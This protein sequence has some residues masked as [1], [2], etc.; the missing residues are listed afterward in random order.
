MDPAHSAQD[1][2]RCYRC[3]TPAP[4]MHCD[5]CHIN[6][7]KACVVVHLSD[8]SKDH[9]VVSFNKRGSTI[10]YPICHKHSRKI[11]EV[12]CNS[13]NI[14]ICA[15]CVSLGYHDQ[16]EKVEI[17]G[18]V[19]GKKELIQKDLQELKKSIYPKYQQ[20]SSN[21]PDQKADVRNHSQKLKTVLDKQREILHTEIDT[22]IQGMKS[23]IDNMDAQHIAAIKRH[24]DTIN[25]TITEITR[26]IR[27][28]QD[29]LD[30]DDV[31]LV[32]EYKSRNNEF[33]NLPAQFQV[34]LPTFTPQQINRK[35]IYQQIGSLS[36]LAIHYPTRPLIDDLAIR[37]KEHGRL[38]KTPGAMSSLPAIPLFDDPVITME[39]HSDPI[40]TPRA[41]SSSPERV[42]VDVPWILKE[43]KTEYKALLRVSCLSENALWTC[44]D[45]DKIIKLYS[46]QGKLLKSVR[47]KSGNP[48]RDLVIT[49]SRNL[50]YAD[51][52]DSSINLV[53]DTQIQKLITLRGWRPLGVCSTSSGDLLVIMFSDDGKQ[54]KVVRYCGFSEKQSIQWDDEGEPLYTSSADNK[55]LCENRNLDICVT[56]YVAGAV[57]VVSAAGK[58]RFRYTGPPSPIWGSFKPD[59]ITTDIRANILIADGENHR[60]HIID[61]HGH[62]LRFIDK[63]GL[64]YPVGLCVDFK[65]N[66]IVAERSTSKVKTIQYY[67]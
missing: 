25:N 56:D 2:I 38:M 65:D 8:E 39:E 17:L 4:P 3:D 9:K 57:V 21:I 31:C 59:N 45:D 58:L 64:R 49:R 26:A 42:F 30:A 27:S 14:P 47:T 48:P 37:T 55:S 32:Y 43:I 28:I 66:I 18:I 29:L 7:C 23:E 54:T 33:R 24:E 36:K 35:Q 51:Y 22:I 1:L 50:V 46:L 16:H 6:L 44:G 13:C 62:F 15:S 11:C 5:S 67:K 41:V 19:T 60:I 34:T 63:T 10:N 61:Q 52:L 20:A 53:S 12:H 40:K